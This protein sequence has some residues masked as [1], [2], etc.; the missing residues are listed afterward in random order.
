MRAIG[1][2]RR[3]TR[4]HQPSRGPGA[5]ETDCGVMSITGEG[6]LRMGPDFQAVRRVTVMVTFFFMREHG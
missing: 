1:P 4:D 5:D 6:I 3:R 2:R